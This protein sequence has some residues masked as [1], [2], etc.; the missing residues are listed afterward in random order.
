MLLVMAKRP[1]IL[2]S[3]PNKPI[4]IAL[5]GAGVEADSTFWTRS[6]TR[7]QS[8]WLNIKTSLSHN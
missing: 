8:S 7:Q 4:I 1:D 2:N 3:Y 6:I 5:H